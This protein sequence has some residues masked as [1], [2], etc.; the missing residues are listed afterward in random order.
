MN[1]VSNCSVAER[2]LG[3]AFLCLLKQAV[4]CRIFGW[5]Q[6]PRL[7]RNQSSGGSSACRA[8]YRW[9]SASGACSRPIRSSSRGQE[10]A[11]RSTPKAA[12]RSRSAHARH[13][14][15]ACR[16]AHHSCTCSMLTRRSP[17][18]RARDPIETPGSRWEPS[19]RRPARRLDSAWERASPPRAL[20][21]SISRPPQRTTNAAPACRPQRQIVEAALRQGPRHHLADVRAAGGDSGHVVGQVPARADAHVRLPDAMLAVH[22]GDHT[23]RDRI[24]RPVQGPPRQR[25]QFDAGHHGLNVSRLMV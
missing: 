16:S 4:P 14:A 1:R 25:V 10:L 3:A 2:Q 6:R 12:R 24:R 22:Q 13:C 5:P 19:Q 15:S 11:S 8:R 17:G 18:G 20:G 21:C 7:A 9:A 23:D